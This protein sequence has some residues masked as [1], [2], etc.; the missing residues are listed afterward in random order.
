MSKNQRR[1][2]SSDRLSGQQDIRQWAEDR[3]KETPMER[4][5]R[6]HNELADAFDRH[7]FRRRSE[8]ESNRIVP[9]SIP[10]RN[11]NKP[12]NIKE[13]T[14][15]NTKKNVIPIDVDK[16][17]I[18]IPDDSE[19]IDVESSSKENTLIE[20]VAKDNIQIEELLVPT[21]S[22]E[23]SSESLER[24]EESLES[25]LESS[26]ESLSP[27][28]EESRQEPRQEQVFHPVPPD[29]VNN[30]V[31]NNQTDLVQQPI[32]RF[33]FGP[34]SQPDYSDENFSQR[35]PYSQDFSGINQNPFI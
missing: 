20:Q 8:P 10:K 2:K 21:Q 1:K 23:S 3:R 17:I 15:K 13:N 33:Y 22:M 6:I 26:A 7:I 24:R 27:E 11:K 9:I 16:D 35:Y 18:T 34:E 12:T 4:A 19:I 32:Q 5:Q 29:A 14:K 30:G 25:S 31:V 28:R